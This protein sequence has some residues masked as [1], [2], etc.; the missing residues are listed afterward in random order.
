MTTT[1]AEAAVRYHEM[2]A[3]RAVAMILGIALHS[4][5]SFVP[6]PWGVQDSEQHGVFGTF[7]FVVHGFRMPVFFVM[8]GF[9][10]AMLWRRRGLVSILNQRFMRVF[11]P[12]MIGIFTICPLQDW[13]GGYVYTQNSP[14]W[15]F[16][17]DVEESNSTDLT[18]LAR[19][20]ELA[21]VKDLLAAGADP[22]DLAED[23][24]SSLHWAAVWGHR[25]IVEALLDAG[26]DP[27]IR[28]Q[29]GGTPLHWTVFL[30]E[31]EMVEFLLDAGADPNVRNDKGES[32]LDTVSYPWNEEIVGITEWIARIMRLDVDLDKI[33]ED[34]PAI[35]AALKA[36]GAE[37]GEGIEEDGEAF[38]KWIE[39]LFLVNVFHHLWFLWF[40]CWLVAAFAMYAL[41]AE[42]ISL[43]SLPKVMIV[44]PLRYLWL[45]P[46]TLLPQLVMHSGGEQPGFGPDTAT[47]WLPFPHLLFYY[48]TFFFGAFYYDAKDEEDR[49]GK[50]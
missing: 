13:V 39:S 40:L 41:C 8:S 27:D 16:G 33:E 24:T 11:L 7:F 28:S 42:V 19:R 43:K 29:D 9:F 17:R 26:A 32:P 4:A 12:C 20:G 14:A 1:K 25:E 35:I 31:P 36:A 30:G 23:K 50:G 6:F 2:D 22:D 45:I 49:L 44:S 21:G 38:G 18:E 5:L 46:L 3:L 48:A 37:G 34:R 15:P 10:T 47:G